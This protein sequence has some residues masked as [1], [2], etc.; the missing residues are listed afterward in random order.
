MS[1]TL[2]GHRT[3]LN[4]K[5]APTVSRRRQTIIAVQYNHDLLIIV[6]R[7]PKNRSL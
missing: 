2:Q 3:E 4:E 1:R 7:R 5:E 6:E